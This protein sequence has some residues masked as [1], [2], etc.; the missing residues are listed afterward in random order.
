[1]RGWTTV[2]FVRH[3]MAWQ[4]FPYTQTDPRDLEAGSG[5]Q[6]CLLEPHKLLK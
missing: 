5:A 6:V 1:M 2:L 3:I 4:R